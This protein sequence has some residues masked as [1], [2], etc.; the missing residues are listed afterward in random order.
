MQF[1]YLYLETIELQ[2]DDDDDD[3][4]PISPREFLMTN[5][6]YLM[7]QFLLFVHLLGPESPAY[8]RFT[9]NDRQLEFQE[10]YLV[11]ADPQVLGLPAES[12]VQCTDYNWFFACSWPIGFWASENR[13]ANSSCDATWD[14]RRSWDSSRSCSPLLC[15]LKTRT[16]CYR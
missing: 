16:L 1:P 10:D 8:K 13:R 6:F 14:S 7:N 9:R 12:F 5:I 4:E 15:L 11:A 2:N 3:E